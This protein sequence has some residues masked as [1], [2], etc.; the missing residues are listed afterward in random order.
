MSVT[1]SPTLRWGD[2][3]PGDAREARGRVL[4]AAQRCLAS[5]GYQRVTME[6]IAAE[7]KISRAT[8]YRYFSS[9]DEVLSGVVVR[10]AERHLERIYPR[11]EAERDLGQAILQFIRL[12]L[13]AALRDPHIAL[14]FTS[15]ESRF[16]G[17]ILAESSLELFEMVADVIRRLTERKP[18]ELRSDVSIDDTSEWIVRTLLSLLTVRGPKRRSPAALDAYLSRFLLPALLSNPSGND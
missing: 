5:E 15:D 7:A 2:S 1:Y 6:V 17:G 10:E 4:D 11:L 16:A 18:G 14:M 9:R 12:T 3:S 8:L 13:R